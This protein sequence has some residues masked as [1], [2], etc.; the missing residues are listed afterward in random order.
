MSWPGLVINGGRFY[1]GPPGQE[2]LVS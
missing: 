1:R 2:C